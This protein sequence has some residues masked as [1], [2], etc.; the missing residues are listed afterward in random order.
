[1]VED[2]GEYLAQRNASLAG[3]LSNITACW[4]SFPTWIMWAGAIVGLSCLFYFEGVW[5]RIFSA[6]VATYCATQVAY[7][8]GVYHG[9]ARGYQAGRS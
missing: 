3:E 6:V 7:R 8:A 5:A 1:M 2:Y 4:W 9:F